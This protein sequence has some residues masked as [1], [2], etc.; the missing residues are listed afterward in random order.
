MKEKLERRT[1]LPVYL[2]T[3]L[4]NYVDSD[5]FVPSD[6]RKEKDFLTAAKATLTRFLRENE[7]RL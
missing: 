5:K 7:D 2:A 3:A 6:K 4:E 1:G